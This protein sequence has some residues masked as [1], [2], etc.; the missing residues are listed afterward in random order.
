[1]SL[2][3]VSRCTAIHRRNSLQ[4]CFTWICW[5]SWLNYCREHR[6][7]EKVWGMFKLKSDLTM[8]RYQRFPIWWHFSSLKAYW[9][10]KTTGVI[11][12]FIS[13]PRFGTWIFSMQGWTIWIFPRGLVICCRT[14]CHLQASA[15]FFSAINLD[16]PAMIWMYNFCWRYKILIEGGLICIPVSDSASLQ[17]VKCKCIYDLKQVSKP[18]RF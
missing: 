5:D 6:I 17:P 16:A 14:E 18:V 3:N 1:M 4:L 8:T 12:L 7:D 13:T 15:I 9:Y 10:I 2:S 11:Q